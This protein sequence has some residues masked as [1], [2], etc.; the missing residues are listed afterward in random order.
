[1]VSLAGAAPVL[2]HTELEPGYRLAKRWSTSRM[3]LKAIMS[4]IAFSLT[5]SPEQ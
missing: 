3:L 5:S 4:A 1:M 2:D